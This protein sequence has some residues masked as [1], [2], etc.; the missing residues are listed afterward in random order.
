MWFKLS[1]LLI[2]FQVSS[3]QFGVHGKAEVTPS[4]APPPPPPT[5][6]PTKPPT[7]AP[8]K[9]PT[10]APARGHAGTGIFGV[11]GEDF[12]TEAAKR[13]EVVT[14]KSK[15]STF[16]SVLCKYGIHFKRDCCYGW[17]RVGG[18]CVPICEKECVHGKCVGPNKCE[19]D[20]GFT[21]ALCNQDYNECGDMPWRCPQ[22]CMNTLGSY[23]CYCDH[24]YVLQQDKITCSRDNRCDGYR[25]VVGCEQYEDGFRCIC[26]DGLR[27][28]PNGLSCIDI[29]ECKEDL[30]N[31]A[32]DRV[33][34]NTF[35]N[36]FCS[37][38]EGLSYNYDI[39]NGKKELV[40]RDRNE[41]DGPNDCDPNANCINENPGYSCE[42]KFGYVGDGSTCTELDSRTCADFPCFP[43]AECV[44][45]GRNPA[46]PLAKLFVCQSCPPGYAGDG[47]D[48]LKVER[49]LLVVVK[50]EQQRGVPVEE[51]T[52]SVLTVSGDPTAITETFDR[53]STNDDGF[54]ELSAPS[55]ESFIVTVSKKG[56]YDI[57]KT[58][59]IVPGKNALT[60]QLDRE[61]TEP[62]D[63]TYLN[64]KESRVEFDF[65]KRGDAIGQNGAY[66]ITFPPGSLNV[67]NGEVLSVTVRG[68]DVRSSLSLAKAPAL[69]GTGI[70]SDSSNLTGYERLPLESFGMAEISVVVKSS[71]E[72]VPLLG[73][74]NIELPLNAIQNS[75][76]EGETVGAFFYDPEKGVWY[77]DGDGIVTTNR[78]G[79]KVWSYNATH[80]TWWN[81]DQVIENS[82][83]VTVTACY[84]PDCYN[85]AG[86]TMITL[87]GNDFTYTATKMT[88]ENGQTCFNFK[89]GGKVELT[90]TCSGSQEF[91][92]GSG[93]YSTCPANLGGSGIFSNIIES[94]EGTFCQGVKF[95]LQGTSHDCSD[96]GPIDNGIRVG[97]DFSY[98]SNVSFFCDSNYYLGAGSARRVCHSCGEWSGSQPNCFEDDYASSGVSES[99]PF[100]P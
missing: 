62:K 75:P 21:G 13:P 55:D 19:C 3:A 84:D 31:C 34:R 39:V 20:P 8:T 77:K 73:H 43:G 58:Y 86:G 9:P 51:A 93:S 17:K 41:C 42:C 23:N 60:I 45:V 83:C 79:D 53:K 64:N 85:P 90:A 63:F 92:V 14:K 12:V 95:I 32:V 48:C 94:S 7:K 30:D 2:C 76:A 10:K 65:S 91:V 15:P 56:Y 59:N 78:Y 67:P 24:G 33:C 82:N 35:G 22:R 100:F 50:D 40:C 29:D 11:H 68:I 46:D 44:D 1:V 97:N 6:A 69:I 81:A 98:G 27:L 25:C 49:K 96:P 70:V 89:Q 88:D 71:G 57:S 61:S 5:K 47:V 66:A 54:A 18:Q 36:F 16:D 72:D 26:P 99:Q 74:I 4:L 80:L 52:V 28:A 87:S 37:C 38:P